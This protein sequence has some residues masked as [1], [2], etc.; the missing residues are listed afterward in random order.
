MRNKDEYNETFR[1]KSLFTGEF[2]MAHQWVAEILV[3][4]K[5]KKDNKALSYKYW[6]TEEKWKKE[7]AKQVMQAGILIKRHGEEAVIKVIKKESWTYS[8]FNRDII[9]KIKQESEAIKKKPKP[10]VEDKPIENPNEFTPIKKTKKSLL[11]KLNERNK[12]E[13]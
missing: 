11:G 9:A 12:E 3:D 5:A 4:R 13:T 10:K 1:Y 8:L 6:T 2:I 7:F